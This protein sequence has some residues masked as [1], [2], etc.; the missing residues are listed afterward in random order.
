MLWTAF[1]LI[2]PVHMYRQLKGAYTLGGLGALWRTM[3]LLL[4]VTITS[5][6][7]FALL[8]YLGSAD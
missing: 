7:F 2:P 1:G 8:M 4:M 3:W 6:L 5:S